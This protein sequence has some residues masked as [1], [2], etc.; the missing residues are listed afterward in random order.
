MPSD[1]HG[2]TAPRLQPYHHV[3]DTFVN[4]DYSIRL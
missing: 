4:H 2:A 3:F 1:Q